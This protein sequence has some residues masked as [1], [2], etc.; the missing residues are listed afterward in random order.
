MSNLIK[1]HGNP[2]FLLGNGSLFESYLI[3]V[4]AYTWNVGV[5]SPINEF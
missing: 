2:E 4:K 3:S 1:K 5:H